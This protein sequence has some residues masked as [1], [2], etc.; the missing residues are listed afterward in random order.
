M[1]DDRDQ[2]VEV[3]SAKW[4]RLLEMKGHPPARRRWVGALLVFGLVGHAVYLEQRE[5]ERRAMVMV[6]LGEITALAEL[7]AE[8]AGSAR[9]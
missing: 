5:T 3:G 2:W 6:R 1:P 9:R 4:R 7:A 8:R